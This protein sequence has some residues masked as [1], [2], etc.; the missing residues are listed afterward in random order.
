MS[1]YIRHMKD[2]LSDL[3]IEPETKEERKEVDLAIRNAIGKK[4]TDK[5][6]EVW[7]EVK[8]WLNDNQ[9]KQE[10][11]SNLMNF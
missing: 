3:N 4:S 11:Q 9:K 7:A 8:I 5:C 2:F 1:C 10:L 6:N